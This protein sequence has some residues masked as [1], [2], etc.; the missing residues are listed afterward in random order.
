MEVVFCGNSLYLCML[1]AGLQQNVQLRISMTDYEPAAAM[2]ELKML[3]PDVLVVEAVNTTS[4]EIDLSLRE[5]FHR[6]LIIV[7][8]QTDSIEVFY[9]DRRFTASV[10]SLS[11]V[12]CKVVSEQ[13][14]TL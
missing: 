5:K 11:Q 10:N 8:R 1:A 7:H 6:M 13:Q 4:A 12:I 9:E 3:C 2:P 14:N